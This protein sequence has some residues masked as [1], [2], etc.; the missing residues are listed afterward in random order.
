MKRI[1]SRYLEPG[2]S[3]DATAVSRPRSLLRLVFQMLNERRGGDKISPTATS[4]MR[5]FNRLNI[6]FRPEVG[7]YRPGMFDQPKTAQAALQAKSP[8]SSQLP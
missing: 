2:G 7:D 8:S 4:P 3:S 1:A 6:A 5:G